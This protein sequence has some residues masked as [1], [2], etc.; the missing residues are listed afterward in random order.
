MSSFAAAC[1]AA[2]R[3]LRRSPGF[4]ALALGMLALGIGATVAIFSVFRSIVLSPL[5]YP[6][7]ARLVGLSAANSAKALTMP[8]LSAS[9]F[10]DYA[11]RARAYAQLAAYRPDFV[12]Y[13][14]A[15]GDPVQLVA[16]HV[17]EHFFATLGVAAARG[18]TFDAGEFSAAAPRTAILSQSAW[19]RH[20]GGRADVLGTTVILND[21]PTTLIGVMPDRF[22]EPEFA[23]VWLPF[24]AESPEYFARDSRFW[25]TIGRLAPERSLADAQAEAAVLADTLAR[26]YPATNKGWTATV[27]PLLEMRISG[28]RRTLLLLGGAVGL[29]LLVACV[30]LANLML[31]RGVARLPELAVRLALGA[32]PR[33]LA[34]AVFLESLLLSLLG[35]AAGIGLAHVALPA[36]AAQLPAALVPR[37]HEIAVDGTALLFAFGASVCTGI[38]FGLLPAWQVLRTDV[39][40]TLKS[41]GSRG[42]TNGFAARAQG[43]LIAGQVA[44]TLVVLSGAALLMKSLFNL[45]R[46]DPGFDAR[47]ILTVRLAPPPSKWETLRELAACY[48]RALDEVR[49]VPGVESAAVNSSTPLTGI[50]LRYPFWVEGRPRTDGNADDAVFNSVTPDY[51]RTLRIPLRQGRGLDE[52]DQENAVKVCLIN[53]TLAQRLFPGENPLGKRIQ[54]LPW[55]AREY[56]EVVGVVADVKQDNLADPAPAQ[57]YVPLA[58]S[59]W[60]FATMVIRTQ[61]ASVSAAAIQAALRRADPTASMTIRT[62]EDSIALTSTVPRL[63]ALLFGL[64]AL[65][66]LGLSAFGIY[67]SMAFTVNQRVRE[68]GVRLALG[69]TP[70]RVLREVLVRAGRLALAGVAVGLGGALALGQLLRGVLHGVEP[71]DPWVLAGLAVFIPLVALV[72]SAQPAVTAARL[73]PI[74]A[75]QQE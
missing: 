51:L 55:L 20:F 3:S 68:I 17:T 34:R 71:H 24:P 53:Q 8:A 48:D 31:A 73:N 15:G 6:E 42:G 54:T 57:I 52:R 26:E 50:T 63:R 7:P 66:A 33:T 62:L 64:F 5:P 37:A 10:R 19:R 18:R 13:A 2:L 41:G 4:T 49:R 1:L 67:A 14:P 36:L 61:G 38:V 27:Q 56:R 45:Q 12:S 28:L 60:F 59:P 58:Q 29:V 22:R 30:N 39:N 11:Q 47:Q 75:L 9:D 72:A 32:T 35:G 43:A 65:G 40:E 69:A 16:A 70:L 44:L 74:R 23:D 25:T 46:T 21:V